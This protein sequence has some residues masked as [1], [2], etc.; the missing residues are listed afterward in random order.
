[1]VGRYTHTE[2]LR[3]LLEIQVREE[4]PA[5][6]TLGRTPTRVGKSDV[7]L[8]YISYYSPSKG[9]QSMK[10]V[11]LLS[12]PITLEKECTRVPDVLGYRWKRCR[13][14]LVKWVDLR[15][16]AD[17]AWPVHGTGWGRH[18]ELIPTV[19]PEWRYLASVPVSPKEKR[20][21]LPTGA[22]RDLLVLLTSICNRE[23][24]FVTCRY[25]W[26]QDYTPSSP[27]CGHNLLR[28]TTW[29]L[30]LSK[31]DVICEWPSNNSIFFFSFE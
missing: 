4:S 2:L 12:A 6:T 25:L 29:S 7:W 15:R 22:E 23:K 21:Q 13:A 26:H 24:Y 20:S 28:C 5:T 16:P 19:I 18:L 8:R 31:H 14:P 27:P 3:R 17:T 1:M 9:R 30:S 11:E 10:Q